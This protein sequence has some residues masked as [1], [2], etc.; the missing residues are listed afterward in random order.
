[1]E[2]RGRS[3]RPSNAAAAK[4][5]AE[6]YFFAYVEALNEREQSWGPFSA[7]V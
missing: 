1:M 2:A 3:K 5:E 4:R 7:S 6:A